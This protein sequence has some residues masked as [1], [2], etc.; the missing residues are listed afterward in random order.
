MVGVKRLESTGGHTSA[1]VNIGSAAVVVNIGPAG[2]MGWSSWSSH[3]CLSLSCTIFRHTQ[4]QRHFHKY[5]DDCPQSELGRLNS[6]TLGIVRA[7]LLAGAVLQLP[8]P[9]VLVHSLSRWSDDQL[10]RSLCAAVRLPSSPAGHL[11]ARLCAG[12]PRCPPVRPLWSPATPA[13]TSG[14]RRT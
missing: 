4:W 13:G 6:R 8:V 11:S 2:G 12:L 10:L 1:V 7:A 5:R 9:V 14:D 3:R